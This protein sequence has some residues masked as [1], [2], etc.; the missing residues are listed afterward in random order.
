L[1]R[2]KKSLFLFDSIGLGVFTITG[3][4]I[5]IQNGLNP[6]IS[7]TLGAITGTFG[8]VIRDFLCNV[9]PIIFIKEIYATA[10]LA[11][12]LSFIILYELGINVEVIY[13]ITSLIVILIRDR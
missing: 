6:I 8:G 4:E 10:S 7:M 12:G 5:G 1:D 11:G 2:L 3:V 9:I 13:I